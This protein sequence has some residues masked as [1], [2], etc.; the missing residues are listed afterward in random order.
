LTV[1]EDYAEDVA[2]IHDPGYQE[3]LHIEQHGIDFIPES[4][5]WATPRDVG[6]MWA[7]ASV[8]IEYFI[9]G[10]ILMTFGLTFAQVIVI[11]VLGNLSYFLLGLCSLQGP[12][13]GTTVFAIN[14]APFGPNGSR[15]ISFFNWITQIGFEVEGLILIVGSGLVLMIKAGYL[16][17]DPAKVI[18]VIVAVLVQGILPFLGHAAILKTLRWLVLPFVILFAILLGFAVP[19]ANTH[20]V[21]TSGDWQSF[22]EA[23]AFTIA[24]SGL[25]WTENGNDYTRYCPTNTSKKGI[26]GWVF[27]GTA[28]P[29]ILIMTLGALVGTFVLKIGTGAGGLLPFA[30]T[31]AIPPWF[32]VVFLLF[33]IVQLFGINSLDMYSSGVTLQAIGV[34]VKRYQAVLVD[35]VI[36]FGVTMYAIFSASFTQ[37]LSDF[38]DIVIIW[39]APWSAIF[40]VDWVLRRYRYVPSELQKTGR[41]SLYWRKGGI[42]WPAWVAQLIGMFAAISALSATFHLPVALNL[43]T[44]HTRDAFGFGADF[45]I[46]LGMGVGG[47][48]YL[49]LAL[50][51]VRKEADAQASLLQEE[52]LLAQA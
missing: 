10:A 22:L 3:P 25:G 41:D 43:V 48:V 8:Q 23:L 35:C 52:G 6:G 12:N 29:E 5:R 28:V 34:P 16:P 40:L 13:A 51:G 1:T 21:K 26:V 11:I 30:H 14:R 46:F 24:L 7:G 19:H 33:A 45:S 39:I 17:G 38:V 44:Y 27:L 42:H 18:L 37:Y 9:Y 50:R 20:L 2:V 4:E 47:L 49:V 36:A 15:P 32:V 31:S